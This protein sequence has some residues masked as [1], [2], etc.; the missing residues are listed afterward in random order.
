M[1]LVEDNTPRAD[2]ADDRLERATE[3]FLRVRS[4]SASV[5][6]LPELRRWME[7]DPRNAHAYQRVSASWDVLENHASAPEIVIGR[8]DALEDARRATQNR[9]STRRRFPTRVALVASI[10]LAVVTAVTW[11]Y[12]QRGVY[13]TDLGERRTLTLADGSVVTLDARSR[14]RVDYRE[15]DRLITLEQGQARFDVAKDPARPFRVRARDQTV[16]ALGTQF[17]VELVSGSVLVTMIEGHVAVTGVDPAGRERSRTRETVTSVDTRDPPPSIDLLTTPRRRTVE[18]KAGEGLR[19]RADGQASVVE[20]VDIERATAWQ[21]GK[22]FFSNEPLASAAERINRYS[23]LQV[24]VDPS[25]ANVGVSGVFDA[26]DAT[27]F[28]EAVSSYFPVDVSREGSSE[29]RLTARH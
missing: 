15:S 9:W 19:V 14:V 4:E 24:R 12:S 27:P 2:E 8:R 13:E 11:F 21:S 7:S 16:I 18:L 5:E 22:L 29:V 20:K 10:V 3:W 25:A 26:G 28:I 23:A 17:N 6:D 1:S